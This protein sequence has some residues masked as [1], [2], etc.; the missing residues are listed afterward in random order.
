VD[1]DLSCFEVGIAYL[2]R[3]NLANELCRLVYN[4]IYIVGGG[5]GVALTR[6]LIWGSSVFSSINLLLKASRLLAAK[7]L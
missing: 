4:I 3:W 6:T 7:G 5:Q 2:T 1:Q